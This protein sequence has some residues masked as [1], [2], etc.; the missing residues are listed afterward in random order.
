MERLKQVDQ[1]NCTV[2]SRFWGHYIDLIGEKVLPYQWKLLNDEVPNAERSGCISNFRIA[3]GLQEG[4]FYGAVFQDSDLAKWIDAVGHY[5]AMHENPELEQCADE[6]IELIGKAQQNDGY[7]DTY[8][9]INHQSQRWKNLRDCHELYCAGHFIEAG[10]SY[11][12]ATGKRKLLDIVIKLADLICSV[13]GDKE[14][15]I[16]GYPGHEEIEYALIQLFEITGNNKYLAEAEYFLYKR[17]SKPCYFDVESKQQDF[18]EVFPEIGRL[19]KT[20]SQSHKPVIEQ[21]EAVGHAVR[22]MYLYTAMASLARYSDDEK[23]QNAS[24]LLW[25]DTVLHK[26]YIT[27]GIGSTSIGESFSSPYDLPNNSAYCETCASI[28]LMRFSEELFLTKP[29]SS[30]G[31]IIERALYNTVLAGI[32]FDGEHFFYVNPLESVPAIDKGN[33][34]FSHV[35]TVRQRWFG[36]ACCPPNI[37]RTLPDITSYAYAVNERNLFIQLYVSGSVQVNRSLSVLIDTKYPADGNIRLVIKGK[38]SEKFSVH[39]RIPAWCDHSVF[40]MNGKIIPPCVV[41]GYAVFTDLNDGDELF[42]KSDMQ[43]FLVYPTPEITADSGRVAVQ[44][45]PFVYCAE[46]VDNG[47]V[48]SAFQIPESNIPYATKIIGIPDIYHC[49]EVMA[50]KEIW[51]DIKPYSNKPG[52]IERKKLK[53]VPYCAWNNRGEGEM[54]VWIRRKN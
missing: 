18:T 10:I 29:D 39:V 54:C 17:G 34:I 16:P 5:L 51:N 4:E 15:Q 47:K 31:D 33:P 48:L 19:G 3:A 22:A 52:K 6:A 32:S 25:A 43:A 12:K 35:R 28:G 50:E 20:Y 44:K 27:G 1:K 23:M 13:F 14:G 41:N 2:S 21:K 30:F 49:L 7:L 40:F 8:F 11:Y 53:L 38:P 26:M 37:A 42:V 45:G 24:E 46:E 9:I 36:V